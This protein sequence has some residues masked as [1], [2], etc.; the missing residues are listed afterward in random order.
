MLDFATRVHNH[1]FRLDP[2]VRSL[3]DIDFYKLLMQQFICQIYPN[4]P[5]TF[6]LKN[7]TIKVRVADIIPE[8]MLREQ[9][10]FV[11]KLRFRENELVWLAGNKFYGRRDVFRPDYIEFLR[12]FR[13]P[14]YDLTVEDGQYVLTVS[15]PWKD[16]TLWELYFL[17]I[18]NELRTRCA[19]SG[20][21]K[22]ELDI[23]YS[24]AKSK[25]W[26]KTQLLKQY[27]DLRFAEFGTRRRHSFLWQDYV[28]GMFAA[29]LP[30]ICVGTSNA[31]H[32]MQYGL[33]ATGTN[34]HELPMVLA[35]LAES[36]QALKASQYLV[37][38]QWAKVYDGALLIMLP[39]TFG[40]TQF[41]RNAPDWA[42]KWTG[43]RF[44]SKENVE[45]G[46]E[47]I[48]WYLSRGEDPR[49]K[50]GMFTD[51]LDADTMI[52]LHVKFRGRMRESFGWGT[53]A[54]NDFR[55]CHP[56]GLDTLDPI[57]LVCKVVAA[58]GRS[59]VK[60][61]DNPS[62]ATGA[63]DEIARYLRVFGDDHAAARDV[64]V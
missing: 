43:M 56:R 16:G 44:D 30:S 28:V 27:P 49:D 1:S 63:P 19:M 57:S 14:D 8:Q 45:A 12:N 21:S 51:G 61:S 23:L 35:C 5:V 36:D 60:I 7:R 31:Y 46:E 64:L 2:I 22:Y 62:K 42:A 29:E 38:E 13:L 25:I 37:L 32:A 15:A 41:L 6:A 11:K 53:L 34:A 39:D 10:D 26:A 17:E 4:V 40:T 20:L 58:N 52:D 33:E 59:A 55:D 54:T 47:M 24:R 50:R 18:V 3:L 48:A 9:L